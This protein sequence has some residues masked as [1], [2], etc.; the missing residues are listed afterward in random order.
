VRSVHLLLARPEANL[1]GGRGF[2]W[3][4]S[5]AIAAA[6][7]VITAGLSSGSQRGVPILVGILGSFVVVAIEASLIQRLRWEAK[8][9]R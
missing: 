2:W 9:P 4:W 3:L 8:T 7:A 5:L 6:G 1:L